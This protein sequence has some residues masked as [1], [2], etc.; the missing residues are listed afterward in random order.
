MEKEKIAV[1]WPLS[2][3][4]EAMII[5]TSHTVELIPVCA[6]KDARW[7]YFDSVIPNFYHLSW[8]NYDVYRKLY[9]YCKTRSN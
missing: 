5:L 3:F 9:Q 8:K 7:R 6:E 1:V 4:K 2:D